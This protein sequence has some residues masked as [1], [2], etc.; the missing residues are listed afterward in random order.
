MIDS[1]LWGKSHGLA[2]PYP[3]IGHLVDS[4]MVCEAVW[5]R[6]LTDVQR[7]RVAESLKI[8]VS[9]AR[10]VVMLWAGLHDLG[11]I[12]PQFQEL[13]AGARPVHCRFLRESPYA[14]APTDGS[15]PKKVRHE[16]ATQRTLPQLLTQLGYPDSGGR[17]ARQLRVQVAQVLGGHHGR[18]PEGIEPRDLRDPLMGLPELGDGIW[19]E[20]RREHVVALHE[21]LGRPVVP[22]CGPGGCQLRPPGEQVAWAG[23][24]LVSDEP[25]F[26]AAAPSPKAGEPCRP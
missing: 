15:K 5:D 21:V 3:V 22:E 2:K 12:M 26:P 16:D 19:A 7:Q 9:Q 11:K 20:Q 8:D 1:R 10:Q 25:L 4:A 6:V 24:G 14:Y 18:Y 17:L 13:A 23:G